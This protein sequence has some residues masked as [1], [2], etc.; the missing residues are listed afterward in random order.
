MSSGFC[1]ILV[2]FLQNYL[3]LLVRRLH[4]LFMSTRLR[5]ELAEPFRHGDGTHAPLSAADPDRE[6]SMVAVNA[7]ALVRLTRA[8]LPAV[9][10]TP[11]PDP[12]GRSDHQKSRLALR[13]Q[14]IIVTCLACRRAIQSILLGRNRFMN[15]LDGYSLLSMKYCSAFIR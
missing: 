7:D 8:V 14:L 11:A 9:S 3:N 4:L 1:L 15:S 2:S 10:L 12:L 13:V 6:Y 5:V